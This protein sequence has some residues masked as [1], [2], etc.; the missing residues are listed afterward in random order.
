VVSNPLTV[1][2]IPAGLGSVTSPQGN[3]P[4]FTQ[5]TPVNPQNLNRYS[6]VRNNPL[7]YADPYGWWTIGGHFSIGFTLGFSVSIGISIYGDSHGNWALTSDSP[8]LAGSNSVS[9]SVNLGLSG[10]SADTIYDLFNETTYTSDLAL[11]EVT[12]FDPGLT[13]DDNG[14]IGG[15]VSV[16]IGGQFPPYNLT[17]GITEPSPDIIGS[18]QML[19]NYS[20]QNFYYDM[21]NT[22]ISPED[23]YYFDYYY[24]GY[25][26]YGYNYDAYYYDYYYDYYGY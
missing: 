26:D 2:A 11:G 12:I 15:S 6:Y 20:P 9:A 5:Q 22:F 25:N 17:M 24:D 13:F 14:L 1:N 3:Y 16:G 23:A 7:T 4:S 21:M 10:T 8:G 18:N 19:E